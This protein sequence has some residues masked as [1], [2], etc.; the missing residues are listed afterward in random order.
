VPDT[1]TAPDTPAAPGRP[2][3]EGSFAVDHDASRRAFFRSFGKQAVTT[4]GQMAGM[5]NI[6]NRTTTTAAA[7]LL[8]LGEPFP[9]R[10]Q[11][12]RAWTGSRAFAPPGPSV[13]TYPADDTYRSPYRVAGDELMI[14]DQR[15][16]PNRLEELVARRGADV[17]Y[18]LRLGACRGGPIMA[19][20]AAYGLALTAHERA[21]EPPASTELELRRTERALSLAWPSARLLGWSVERMRSAE[22]PGED[23]TGG[24]LAAALREEADAIASRLQAAQD[25]IAV[26]LFD[27][28]SSPEDRPLG[29]LLHGDPGALAGGLLG[30]G[31]TALARLDGEGRRLRIFVT[32]TRPFMEGA[33]LAAWEL[34]QAG[35]PYQ[36]I[37]D[38]AVA[39]LFER[40]AI[41]AVLIEADWVAAN[42]DVGA[43]VGSRAI[44]QQASLAPES[45]GRP[46]PSVVVC[47]VSAAIDPATLDGS[48]IPTD[49]RSGRELAAYLGD[50]PIGPA[51][52][53]A[54]V[55]D[56][57][58]AASITSLV[59]E[60]GVLSPPD[61]GAVAALLGSG[62]PASGELA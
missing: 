45:A 17:A 30:T 29:V 39:W 24:T 41:D 21:G 25:A 31:I 14:L 6:L 22:R 42:G 57:I 16:I 8:G 27:L 10:P 37:P 3:T 56:V 54:P 15:G 1:P 61:A 19:Q 43:V 50:V 59:T 47:A 40:E 33:R 9:T 58:P 26:A 36:V 12:R 32:E 62:E 51:D 20:L 2:A 38:A 53:L 34:R 48:A 11:A 46:R 44:A 18:F 49:L 23:L 5:A 28:M 55:I 52:G 60:R 13:I 35:I 4:A 7:N